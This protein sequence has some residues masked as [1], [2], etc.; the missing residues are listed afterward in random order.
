VQSMV[1]PN[2]YNTLKTIASVVA[3]LRVAP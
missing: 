2:M 3:A 1:P